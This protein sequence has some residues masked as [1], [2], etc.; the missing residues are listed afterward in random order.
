[1]R[2]RAEQQGEL[3]QRRQAVGDDALV[4]AAQLRTRF[5]NDERRLAESLSAK[6]QLEAGLRTLAALEDEIVSQAQ[7]L[8][9][10]GNRVQNLT[11]EHSNQ[12]TTLRMLE[13]DLPE[14][15][16]SEA[17]L[18]AQSAELTRQIQS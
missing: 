7:T 2:E 6:D 12:Q 1:A 5:D 18:L 14:Q 11:V 4:D 15:S 16:R 8:L 10:L 9:A 3:E 13:H 17:Q